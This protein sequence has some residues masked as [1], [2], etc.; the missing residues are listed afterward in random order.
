MLKKMKVF[1]KSI[2]ES[3]ETGRMSSIVFGHFFNVINII[4]IE[5]KNRIFFRKSFLTV[6]KN[7]TLALA[8]MGEE[9]GLGRIA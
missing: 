4:L 6:V 3:M 5:K 9:K 7:T 2:E 8:E 1:T